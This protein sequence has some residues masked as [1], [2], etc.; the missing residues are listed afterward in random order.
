MFSPGRLVAVGAVAALVVLAFFLGTD[1]EAIRRATVAMRQGERAGTRSGG[2]GGRA[3]EP[4][5]NGADGTGERA[6]GRRRRKLINISAEQKRAEDLVEE[7]RLYRQS[8]WEEGDTAMA[9]TLDELER[10]LLDIANSPD[11]V[12][13]AQ[14]DSIQKRI[15]SH[16]ILLKVRVVKDGLRDRLEKSNKLPEQNEPVVR[17]R[18]KI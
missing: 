11:E 7:N 16:G 5:G 12:T 8:A 15:E 9:S 4:L 6:A 10:V 17:E 3:S 2:C 14:F 1:D 18:S 13:P